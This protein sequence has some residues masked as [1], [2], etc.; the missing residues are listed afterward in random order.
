MVTPERRYTMPNNSMSV[1]EKI[2][3]VRSEKALSPADLARQS[4]ISEADL[5]KMEAN[6]L[7][8]PLGVIINLAKAL[9]VPVGDLFGD[10]GDSPFCIV[11]SDDRA[12]VSPRFSSAYAKS[13]GYTYQGLGQQ[14]KN[15]Q[16]EPFLVTLNPKEEQDVLANRHSGE[17]FIYVLEGKVEVSLLDHKAI[18]NPGDSIYYDSSVPHIISC[19]GDKSA[20]ILAVIYIG[21]EMII[22]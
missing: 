15:R 5:A 3:S 7:A 13:C 22:L 10:S 20:K 6:E 4:G 21:E 12:A 14:K 18:L 17:E 8:P 11:R 9:A 2:K 16:M 1:G 19:H